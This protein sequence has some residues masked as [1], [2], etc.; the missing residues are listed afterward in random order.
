MNNYVSYKNFLL[1]PNWEKV[2][3]YALDEER[4]NES[5]L[6]TTFTNAANYRVAD[7]VHH[8]EYREILEPKIQLFLQD[9]CGKLNYPIFTPQKIEMQ[10]TITRDGGFYKKHRDNGCAPNR[11][12]KISY[13][14]YL[15]DNFLGGEL[16]IHHSKVATAIKPAP[17][18]L[19]MFPS[20]VEHEIY[21]VEKLVGNNDRITINGWIS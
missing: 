1:P 4:K 19:V 2:S 10:L 13:V 21:P 8:P 16:V 11:G 7:I 9:A 15:T 6:A 18:S 12:R 14:F 3:S 17:N 5:V 20:S